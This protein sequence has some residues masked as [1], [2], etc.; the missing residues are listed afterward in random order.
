MRFYW[1]LYFLVLNKCICIWTIWLCFNYNFYNFSK[2]LKFFFQIFFNF[3]LRKL[4]NILFFYFSLY[5]SYKKLIILRYRFLILSLFSWTSHISSFIISSNLFWRAS[6][7]VFSFH[8]WRLVFLTNLIWSLTIYSL[9]PR[10][11]NTWFIT[12][13]PTSVLRTH[14]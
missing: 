2:H 10:R 5:I 4:N 3:I 13:T 9:T 1:I 8:I 7:L 14:F 6:R 12:T 11:W